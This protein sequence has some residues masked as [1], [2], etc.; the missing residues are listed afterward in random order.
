MVD[1]ATIQEKEGERAAL[2]QA[3][4]AEFLASQ[5]MS[6]QADAA[7]AAKNGTLQELV[8]EKFGE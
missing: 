8:D 7:E 5:G 1:M 2:E 3:A 4:L 6:V